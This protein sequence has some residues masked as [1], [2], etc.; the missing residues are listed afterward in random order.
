VTGHH[1][2]RVARV[3]HRRSTVDELR[4]LVDRIWPRGLSKESADLDHWCKEI[5][6]STDLRRWYAHVPSR[7]REFRDRYLTELDDPEHAAALAQL[8][9]LAR[10]HELTLVTATRELE[11]SQ[12]TVLAEYLRSTLM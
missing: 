3:Y 10:D 1:N 9:S 7:F 2:I 11:T 6:P 8:R 12:A 5:A 4:I